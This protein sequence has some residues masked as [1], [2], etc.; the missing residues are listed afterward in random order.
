MARHK[1]KV[2]TLYSINI[3]IDNNGCFGYGEN[4][5]VWVCQCVQFTTLHM[6]LGGMY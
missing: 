3:I 6:V 1:I 4:D 5:S 2:A